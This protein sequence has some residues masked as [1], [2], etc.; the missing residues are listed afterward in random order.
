MPSAGIQVADVG[1]QPVPVARYYTRISPAKAGVHVRLSPFNQMVANMLF[2]D[3]NG[4]N[5]GKDVERKIERI[6]FREDFRRVYMDEIGNIDYAPR[7]VESYT[8]GFLKCLNV[9]TIQEAGFNLVIDYASAPTATVL[10]GLLTTLKCNVVA[11]NANVDESK[12]SISYA[13]FEDAL[14][15]LRVISA[16][17]AANLAVRIDVGGETIWVV[18]DTGRNI[19][20]TDLCATMADMVLAANPGKAIAI[21]LNLPHI[22]EEI[23]ARHNGRVIR[24]RMDEQS[25]MLASLE[26][27]VVMAADGRGNFIFPDFQPAVDGMMAIAKLLEFLATQNRKLSDIVADLPKYYTA[28]AKIYCMWSAKGAVMRRLNQ[29]FEGQLSPSVE[30]IKRK[31]SPNE[32]VLILPSPDQPHIEIIAEAGSQA[33][34]EA[35]VE[36]YARLVQELQPDVTE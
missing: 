28:Q 27:G 1:V 10:P 24:A 2:I 23:A 19:K 25:L 33:A 31:F 20:G 29:R 11:L 18:D 17:L 12:M 14:Y 3:E 6:F 4:L 36:E 9:Q 7:V 32:W 22:F 35:L 16:A 34:A 15:R 5:L 21:T 13:A 26:E 30:G 8:E